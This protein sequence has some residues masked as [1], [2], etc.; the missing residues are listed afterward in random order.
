[1]RKR[2]VILLLMLIITTG[3]TCEYNLKIENGTYKE[4]VVLESSDDS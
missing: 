3:C 2:I 1:M 4:T